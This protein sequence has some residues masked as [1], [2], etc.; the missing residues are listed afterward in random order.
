MVVICA[1]TLG[2]AGCGNTQSRTATEQLLA[3]DAIDQSIARLDF[4][5]LSGQ[6][7]YLDTSF[8]KSIKGVGFVNAAYI[9]SGIRQQLVASRCLLQE[10]R[11]DAN[12]IV[13]ARIGSLGTDVHEVTYGMPASNA[14]SAAAS[15]VPTLPSVPTIPEIAVAKRNRQEAAA[16]LAVFAYAR[17]TGEPIWQSGVMAVRS[18]ASDIWLFGA[19]PFQRGRIYDGTRF[20]G[21]RLEL[22]HGKHKQNEHAVAHYGRETFFPFPPSIDGSLKPPRLLEVDDGKILPVSAKEESDDSDDESDE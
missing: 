14:I 6:S 18:S 4:S 16:K 15:V 1:V 17:V 9:T 12:V 8:L 11:D 22:D 5:A 13:E 7:V 10:D 21:Q 3:S 2:L 20:A 19:G